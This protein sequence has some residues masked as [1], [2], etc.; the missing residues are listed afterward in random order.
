MMDV[1]SDPQVLAY[2]LAS[3]A[4]GALVALACSSGRPSGA[5]ASEALPSAPS[6]AQLIST[7]RS[8]FP[9]DFTGR[10]PSR[11]LIERALDA[12]RWA[13][14]HGKTEP[15]RFIV[16]HGAESIARWHA[17][18]LEALRATLAGP[19]LEAALAKATKKEKELKNVGAIIGLGVKRVHNAK[20]ALM[21]QWEELAA[22]ACAVQNLHLYLHAS[23]W[24]GYWSSAGCL[25]GWA[26]APSVKA[27]VGLDGECDG[28]PDQCAGWFFVGEK[29]PECKP[30]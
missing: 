20:G 23:G 19:E 8:I 25:H 22:L 21:P 11:A 28:E 6:V 24:A 15:W 17:L 14:T 27:F 26:D 29:R 3:V 12:A 16:F 2:L 30:A 9:K 1:F 7:R 13:P 10:I 4:L 5:P 18:K